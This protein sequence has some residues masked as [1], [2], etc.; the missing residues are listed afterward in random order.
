MQMTPPIRQFTRLAV[1][2]QALL[3]P[4]LVYA[5][6]VQVPPAEVCFQAVTGITGM[7]AVLGA[8]AG[9]SGGTAGTY[10][11]VPLTGGTGSGATANI[12]VAGGAVT[13][14]VILNPGVN[15][16][17]GDTI[18]AF[19]ANIGNVTGFSVTINATT[20]NSAVAGGSVGMYVP[21]TLTTSPTWQNASQATLNINPIPLDSNGCAIIYGV[22]TYRQ[23]LYDSLGNE[24]WDRLTSVAPVN[25]YWAGTASG[26]ANAIAVFD[27]SFNSGNGQAVNF[28]AAHNNTGATTLTETNTSTTAPILKN[29]SSGL[30]A[31]T[32]GEILTGNLVSVIYDATA[33]SW[34]IAN[35]AALASVVPLTQD[36]QSGSTAF[37]IPSTD[38]GKAVI[39]TA[40]AIVTDVLPAAGGS[41]GKG[42]WFYYQNEG[43]ALAILAP[44]SGTIAGL[45]Q[46][47]VPVGSGVLVNSDGS[48]WQVYGV[49]PN[50]QGKW[51]L[52]TLTAASSASLS[53]T[54]NFTSNFK[55]YEIRFSNLV[56]ATNATT[57]ELQVQVGG[58]F[59]SSSYSFAVAILNSSGVTATT[60]TTY[61]P[62]SYASVWANTGQGLSGV[63]NIEN[64]SA[65]GSYKT[66]TVSI[67]GNGSS[68]TEQYIY[69][70]GWYGGATGAVTGINIVATSGNIASG[71]VEIYGWN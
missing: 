27:P 55:H 30:V 65:T 40:S 60:L 13:T 34:I 61:I 10:V 51:L 37:T 12:T 23:I 38:N 67:G 58:S 57:C 71:T 11:N 28:I 16:A 52:N 31:L 35:P 26:T 39:R 33:A 62:C 70:T 5:Q 45:S 24:I 1:L 14:V 48:N 19:S 42:F 29:S 32:G 47:L 69:G 56:S 44:A 36:V 22:G 7:I 2:T 4:A 59:Q 50:Q 8:V 53:D 49:V 41:F 54:T 9:G 3:W 20:I 64:P 15:Y 21:G 6:A 25:P 66:A 18:S 68:N 17:I 63:I 43:T 46:L